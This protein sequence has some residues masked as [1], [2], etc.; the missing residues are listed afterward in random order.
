[1]LILDFVEERE[2]RKINK[3]MFSRKRGFE[4]NNE[5][6][7]YSVNV[8]GKNVIV[9]E[10]TEKDLE[11]EDVL[12]LLK[13]Y[14]SRV[15]VSEN[16]RE[17]EILKE[18]IHNP[19]T[20][21]QRAL[22][23]SFVN[24]IKSVNREW[25][26]ISI[27]TDTFTPFRELYDIVRLSKSVAIVTN[28]NANTEKFLNDCYYEYGAIVS[29]KKEGLIK[30]DVYLDLDEIDNSGKLMINAGGKEFLLYPDIKYFDNCSEYQK[31]SQYNIEHNLICSAFSDK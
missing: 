25:K 19:K 16:Y 8:N 27:K 15:L 10:L 1:M 26:N 30:N 20:Y 9:L 29:V 12:T 2:G 18:Y 22:L 21:Y 17:I 6:K 31:L 23:S 13:I 11:K 7:R 3:K 24:Q 5:L 4:K 14:K 28:P